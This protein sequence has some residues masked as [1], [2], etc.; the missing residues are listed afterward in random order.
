MQEDSK[1][2]RRK[3]HEDQSYPAELML[4]AIMVESDKVTDQV[5][6]SNN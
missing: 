2:I 3:L 4:G 5:K 1:E 6:I